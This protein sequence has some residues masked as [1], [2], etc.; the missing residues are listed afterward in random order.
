MIPADLG[1]SQHV[2]LAL[3]RGIA[4]KLLPA[5][6]NAIDHQKVATEHNRIVA[7]L[8][9][10]NGAYRRA[11]ERWTTLSEGWTTQ[12]VVTK[13]PLAIGLGDASATEVGLRLHHTYGTPYLPGSALKGLCKRA[14]GDFGIDEGSDAWRT[15]FGSAEEGQATKGYVDFH[16]GWWLPEVGHQKLALD[17]MTPHHQ[18]YYARRGATPPTDFDAPIPV[19]FLVVPPGWRFLLATHCIEDSKW[20]DLAMEILLH[21]LAHLGLGGK[22]DA[23]YG[24]LVPS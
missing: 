15:L 12:A 22:T 24:R 20:A 5:D 3:T 13:D 18:D 8:P 1:S 9:V 6:G 2:G 14:A 4:S 19:S 21:G 11:V 10:A 7:R 17:V 23:G 16:Q